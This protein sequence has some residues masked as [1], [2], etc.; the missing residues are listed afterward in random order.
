MK[1]R[2]FGAGS[3][4]ASGST[5]YIEVDN[6]GAT[7][8]FVTALTVNADPTVVHAGATGASADTNEHLGTYGGSVA[9]VGAGGQ[10]GTGM[11]GGH[12]KALSA[13]P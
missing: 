2:I 1:A 5:A 3:I 7:N 8:R 13:T 6:A 4:G 10:K 11:M 12:G 9:G